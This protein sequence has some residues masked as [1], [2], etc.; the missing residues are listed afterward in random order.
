MTKLEFLKNDIKDAVYSA[1][2]ALDA[3]G[4]ARVSLGVNDD[5]VLCELCKAVGNLATAFY[6]A[7]CALRNY[8]E[9]VSTLPEG[10]AGTCDNAS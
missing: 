4:G 7:N 1:R 9:S 10:G 3:L 2:S 8:K 5:A 6:W